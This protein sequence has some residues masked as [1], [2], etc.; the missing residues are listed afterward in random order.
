MCFYQKNLNYN[1]NKGMMIG[2]YINI[3]PGN[4]L[5]QI[6]SDTLLYVVTFENNTARKNKD[7]PFCANEGY[8]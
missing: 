5:S 8:D 2:K 1:A 7:L 3:N 6:S 4:I